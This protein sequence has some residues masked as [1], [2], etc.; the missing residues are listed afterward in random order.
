METIWASEIDTN[1]RAI[2][3]YQF[4]DTELLGDIKE[5]EGLNS[6]DIVTG[7][8]PCQ[9]I[10]TAGKQ[11]GLKGERS[12]LFFE[13]IRVVKY[14][15]PRW[16]FLENVPRLLTINERRD[17]RTVLSELGEC[18]Y[19]LSGR[20]FNSRYFGV[21]QRRRRVFIIG[22]IGGFGAG[23]VL[24]ESKSVQGDFTPRRKTGAELAYAVRANPSR[25]CDKGDGGINQTLITHTLTG[26]GFDASEDGTGRGNPIVAAPLRGRESSKGISMPG[27]GGEDDFNLIAALLTARD[28][29]GPL[30]DRGLGT[31]V[32]SLTEAQGGPDDND[33]QAGYIIPEGQGVRRLTPHECERL[34]GFPDDWTQWGIDEAG[35]E[36]EISDSARYRCLGNAVTVNVISWIGERILDY[37]RNSNNNPVV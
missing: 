7:G 33:A 34:Q 15:Q 8:W 26:E 30:P 6:V 12:G 3:R 23:E 20:V 9:D 11:K 10:S 35:K 27:R 28:A 25:S 14:L 24:F 32:S 18:G 31:V 5:L 22:Y 36:I 21:A 29:K 37:E 1:A 13:I 19:N 4:P 16:V 17:F 2:Y